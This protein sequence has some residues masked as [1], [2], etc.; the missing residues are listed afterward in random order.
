MHMK[1]W[2]ESTYDKSRLVKYA[3]KNRIQ[4]IAVFRTRKDI[5]SEFSNKIL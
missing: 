4:M 3:E 5:N 2:S 1:I